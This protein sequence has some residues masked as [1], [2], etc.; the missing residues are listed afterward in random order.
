MHRILNRV[1]H[2]GT[3][4]FV[5]HHT[6]QKKGNAT[7]IYY[8]IAWYFRKNKKPNRDIIKHLGKLSD[9]EIEYYK[10]AIACLNL[11]AN[12]FPCNIKEVEVKQSLEYLSCAVG[13]HFWKYWKLKHVFP[14]DRNNKEVSLHDIVMILTGLR[15]VQSCSKSRTTQLYNETVLSQLTGVSPASYNKSRLFRELGNIEDYR[16]AL[17]KHIYNYA[18]ENNYTKG[19]LLFYDLSSGNFSGLR[20]LMGKWGHCKDGYYVHV[21]LLLVITPEGYPIYWDVLEGNTADAKTIKGLIT[22]VEKIY[23]HLESI[24][25]FDRGMVSDENLSLL[26]EKSIEFI[27]ALDGNQ[28]SYFDSEIDFSLLSTI[29]KLDYKKQPQQI[30]EI[31]L[32]QGYSYHANNLYYYE[33]NLSNVKIDKKTEVLAL[34]RRRYFLSFNPELAYLTAKHRKERVNEFKNWIENY[35][36]ELSKAIRNRNKETIKNK[37]KREIRKRRIND[38]V[39]SYELEPYIV[40]NKNTKGDVK[41]ASTYKIKLSD[42]T[43]ESFRA[44]QRYDGL[45]ILITNIGKEKDKDFFCKSNFSNYFEIYRLKNTIEES[46]KILSD[47][48]GIEPFYVYKDKHVKAHFTIC[49]L[50]Y[51]IDV[52]ILNRIRNSKKI[53]NIGLER[54]FHKLSKCKQDFIKLKKNKVISK[55]TQPTAEQK[56]ILDVLNCSYLISNDYLC[57]NGIVNI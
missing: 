50:A 35:N 48:V 2:M 4:K 10:D 13:I 27:T 6:K 16:E 25:C 46:F 17:G 43:D 33:I 51:L 7:Y 20:C 32:K 54:I 29:K 52:T 21:V 38:V 36:T 23:G 34:S 40:E 45:W 31:L 49:V 37:V 5:L 56:E 11:E 41:R 30:K 14:T 42:I 12:M 19:N 53:D 28:L 18:K 39:I 44:A 9:E 15:F 47:F 3:N 24:I 8:M 26:D 1:Y 55:I 22:K 57:K